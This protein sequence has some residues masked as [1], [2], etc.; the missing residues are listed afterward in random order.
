MQNETSDILRSSGRISLLRAC[1][2]LTT[3]PT[4][5]CS[6]DCDNLL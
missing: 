6:A 4:D 3:F 5:H 1:P 2:G